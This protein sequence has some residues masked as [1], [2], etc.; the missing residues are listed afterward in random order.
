MLHLLSR[1]DDYSVSSVHKRHSRYLFE[2]TD[3]SDASHGVIQ[4][5]SPGIGVQSVFHIYKEEDV[6]DH[7]ESNHQHADSERLLCQM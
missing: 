5:R 6:G 3:R 4:D 2:I 7:Y 1:W